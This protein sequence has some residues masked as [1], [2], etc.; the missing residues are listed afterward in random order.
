[1]GGLRGPQV[2]EAPRLHH[3]GIERHGPGPLVRLGPR[4]VE[5]V[6]EVTFEY[7]GLGGRGV[8]AVVAAAAGEHVPGL[9]GG[10]QDRVRLLLAEQF[11]QPVQAGLVGESDGAGF[12]HVAVA[13]VDL[14]VVQL[15]Q[16]GARVEPRDLAAGQVVQQGQR[17][18]GAAGTGTAEQDQESSA[19]QL[20]A[21]LPVVLRFLEDPAQPA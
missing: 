5:F 10:Q 6:G 8:D 9:G 1:M 16:V 18:V 19:A 11:A 15:V 7:G 12:Q 4:L 13:L 17:G 14:A 3:L 21:V 20:P 2:V